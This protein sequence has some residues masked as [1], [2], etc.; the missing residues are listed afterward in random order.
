MR[1]AAAEDKKKNKK[2]KK[3]KG[4]AEKEAELEV[5]R[6]KIAKKWKLALTTNAKDEFTLF[7]FFA[8]G[9][10]QSI[11]EQFVEQGNFVFI[12]NMHSNQWVDVLNLLHPSSVAASMAQEG[13]GGNATG[14]AAAAAAGANPNAGG[15]SDIP[16]QV[17]HFESK[18]QLSEFNQDESTSVFSPLRITLK[19][20][21]AEN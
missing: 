19:Q 7:Q 21:Q 8:L 13:G 5:L 11:Y 2:K 6:G 10:S 9:T 17:K 20:D 12:R 3:T 1:V 16:A 14:N 15:V 18:K 4:L